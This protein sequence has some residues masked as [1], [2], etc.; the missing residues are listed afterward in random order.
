MFSNI[1]GK[2]K[3]AARVCCWILI[4]AFVIMGI[5][6]IVG[7][8]GLGGLVTIVVGALAAWVGSFTLYGFGELIENSCIQTNLMIKWDKEK[9]A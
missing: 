1:G 5:A 6:Q 8:N 2:I 3:T 4:A 7:G 9:K